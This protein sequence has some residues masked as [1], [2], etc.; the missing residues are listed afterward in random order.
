MDITVVSFGVYTVGIILVGVF[1]YLR[2]RRGNEDFFLASRELGPWL[3]ALSASSSSESGWVMLGLVGAAFS[4]GVSALWLIPGTVAGYLFNWFWLASRLRRAAASTGAITLPEYLGRRFDS[5]LVRVIAAVITIA[6]MLGYVAGQMN[7][8]GKAFEAVFGLTYET[9]V[10][11]GTAIIL[12]YTASG[13]FRAVV[14]TDFLQ[15][16]LMMGALLV[17]PVLTVVEVGGVSALLEALRSE[18]PKLL[19]FSAG[20]TGMALLG[21]VFGWVGV[22]LGYPGQ[23][24]V[25]VRFMATRDDRSVRVGGLIALIWSTLVF[26]GAIVLGLSCRA[27]LH[28]LADPE[29]ALPIV[30]VQLLP[31]VVAGL[32]LAA[33]LAAICST[34]DSQL[35]VCVSAVAHDLFGTVMR[36]GVNIDWLNRGLVVVLGLAAMA[37]ALT[38]D[39]VVFT[40]VL[41]A[42]AVL[43]AAFGPVL[44]LAL[45]WKGMTKAGAIAGMVAGAVVTVV[46][47]S[48]DQLSSAIYELVP[49]FVTAFVA[50]VLVSVVTPAVDG[51]GREAE[52]T[53]EV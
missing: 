29:Q 30:T 37:A 39:R 2:R 22:G 18:D 46:W 20:N 1:S 47:K 25:L 12:M 5:S 6:A 36:R 19:A 50:A 11:L 24:Q 35:L 33:V 43:G 14:W 17:L 32:M 3:S 9:G 44:I 51:S 7:S 16:L 28:S 38:E 13:G 27:M 10:M 45:A 42:W 40:F 8:A 21:F 48:N 34:A 23:P 52:V 15:A 53:T 49:A 26:L 31:G 41:Y 4:G